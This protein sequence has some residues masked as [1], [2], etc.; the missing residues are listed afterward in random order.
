MRF[1]PRLLM[2]AMSATA[3]PAQMRPYS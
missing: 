2:I 3:M 1:S